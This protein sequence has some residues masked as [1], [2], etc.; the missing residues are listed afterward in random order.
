MKNHT[1]IIVVSGL[2]R[3]GTSLMTQMLAAGGVPILADKKRFADAD[4]PNGYCEFEA[5]RSLE[6]DNFF[7]LKAEGRAVKII[8]HLLQYLPDLLGQIDQSDD[9][10]ASSYEFAD[11]PEILDRHRIFRLTSC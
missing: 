2:P 8:S 11:C 1:P 3:S 10:G 7:L 9:D 5:D 4:N 6:S